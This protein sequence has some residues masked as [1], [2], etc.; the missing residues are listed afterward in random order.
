MCELVEIFI[1]SKLNIF[2]QSN[3]LGLYR[4]DRLAVIKGLSASKIER[5]KE[6]VVKAIKDCDLN[7]TTEANLHTVNYLDVAFDLQKDSYLPYRKPDNTPIYINNCSNHRP[8]VIKQLPKFISKRL[9][10][11][12]SN[13]DIF[14]KTKPAYRD[15]L[16]KKDF[17]RS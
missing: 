17:K 5:L 7:I 10:E 1:L 4:D 2:S 8:T 14:E 9:S 13:E 15:A 16:N 12:S 6:N 11:L 3:A